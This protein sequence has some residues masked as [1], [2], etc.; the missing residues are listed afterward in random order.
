MQQKAKEP[1]CTAERCLSVTQVPFK[2]SDV[3]IPP[4]IWDIIISDSII[5]IFDFQNTLLTAC[6]WNRPIVILKT[7]RNKNG[8]YSISEKEK[9]LYLKYNI[10]PFDILSHRTYN[11]DELLKSEKCC[12]YHCGRIFDVSEIRSWLER[13]AGQTAIC[14]YCEEPFVIADDSGFPVTDGEFVELINRYWFG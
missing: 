10:S 5:S 3:C 8:T 1:W 11:K 9:P 6:F 2:K 12:C 13:D 7:G 4:R 14:P